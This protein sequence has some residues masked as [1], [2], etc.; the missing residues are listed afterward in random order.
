MTVF[1]VYNVK[2]RIEMHFL[3]IKAKM[4]EVNLKP[5]QVSPHTPVLEKQR[6]FLGIV[7]MGHLLRNGS[8]TFRRSKFGNGNTFDVLFISL[9][10]SK[11]RFEPHGLSIQS[12]PPNTCAPAKDTPSEW[13]NVW[14]N[15]ETTRMPF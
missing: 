2:A 10:Q 14:K 13:S 8:R 15:R 3:S 6:S 7:K 5:E 9:A 12:P 11:N 1:R 4:S